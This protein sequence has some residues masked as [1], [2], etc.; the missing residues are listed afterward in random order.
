MLTET[1]EAFTVCVCV[2]LYTTT[3]GQHL[4][5]NTLTLNGASSTPEVHEVEAAKYQNHELSLISYF[6]H[7]CKNVNIKRG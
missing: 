6:I 3:S 7:Y 4:H 5:T 2:V 1:H